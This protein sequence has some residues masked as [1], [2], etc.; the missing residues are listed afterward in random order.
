MTSTLHV[1]RY[2]E[3]LSKEYLN[4]YVREGGASVK[5]VVTVDDVTRDRF[6][7]GIA[8]TA[9]DEGFLYARIDSEMTKAHQVDQLFFELS[10]QAHWEDLAARYVRSAYD[11]VFFPVPDEPGALRLESA[12]DRHG[13]DRRELYRS[14]RRRLEADLLGNG[15]M[16]QQFRLAMLRLCQAQLEAGDVDGSERQAILEW[17]SGNL[18]QISALRSSLIYSRIA[19][20]TARRMLLSTTRWLPTCGRK[21]LVLHLDLGRLFV[22]RRP[23]AEE[24]QGLYYSKTMVLDAYE[25]LRQL[26][27][28]VDDLT[29]T[30]VVVSVPIDFLVDDARG[31]GAYS[32]LQLRLADEVRD[33]RRPNPFASL[34]RLEECP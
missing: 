30:L 22:S 23:P 21:G 2:L 17:L 24:R 10:R 33:R 4:T 25:I 15:Q 34:V 1:D 26:I 7:A 5:F 6:S 32:A 8:R 11:A 13:V 31:L 29:S 20:H 19:R 16:D 9:A 14:I 27:D 28:A 18:R 3:F 12:A